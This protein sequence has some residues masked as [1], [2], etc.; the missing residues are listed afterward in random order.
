MT[1]QAPIEQTLR[2]RTLNEVLLID[3]INELQRS[4]WE[5][6]KSPYGLRDFNSEEL[7]LERI[8]P[9]LHLAGRFDAE[10]EPS[11]TLSLRA[12]SYGKASFGLANYVQRDVLDRLQPGAEAALFDDMWRAGM[13]SL[14]KELK[15]LQAAG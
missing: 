7:I 1:D 4:Y 3:R 11:G 10:V 2:P 14:A 12:R 9:T 6:G 13:Q 5:Q 15:R 8:Q